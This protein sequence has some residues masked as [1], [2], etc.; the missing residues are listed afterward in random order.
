[1]SSSFKSLNKK[2]CRL[3]HQK[4][5]QLL[6][7][8][9]IFHIMHHADLLTQLMMAFSCRSLNREASRI[10]QGKFIAPLELLRDLPQYVA[11]Y[12]IQHNGIIDTIFMVQKLFTNGL[13]LQA[14]AHTLEIRYAIIRDI[15]L[16]IPQK[17]IR[18]ECNNTRLWSKMT[19]HSKDTIRID[20][21][22]AEISLTHENGVVTEIKSDEFSLDLYCTPRIQKYKIIGDGM[23]PGWFFRGG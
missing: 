23:V 6:P 7:W 19:I 12:F 16:P 2:R 17:I 5:P 8:E 9:I 14:G 10:L 3:R 4:R 11:N 20:T 21:S 13:S 22:T 18:R 15:H 1:M